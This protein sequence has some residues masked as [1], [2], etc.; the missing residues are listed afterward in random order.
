MKVRPSPYRDFRGVAQPVAAVVIGLGVAIAACGIAGLVL[1]ALGAPNGG[2]EVALGLSAAVTLAVGVGLFRY[3]RHH[4]RKRISRRE[5]LLA[6]CLIWGAAGVFGGLPFVLGAGLS[7]ADA[8]FE[9][10]SG[11]TTTGATVVE[12][13]P[14]QLTRPLMLWRSLIQWLGGMGIVVLFVAV[15]PSLGA[16]GKHMFKGEVPGATAEGLEPRIAETAS[17]LWR[18]YV[19]FTLLEV[20]VLWGLG[21]DPFTAACHAMTT[22]STG[23]FSTFNESAAGFDSPAVEYALSTFM[24]I[25]TVNYGL[26]YAAIK[27]RSARAF[28]RSPEFLVFVVGTLVIT[29]V[30]TV[31]TLDAHGGLLDSLRGSYFMVG[32]TLS[33]TGYGAAGYDAYPPLAISILVGMMFVG[34]CSGSTAGGIK[35]ERVIVLVKQARAQV[36]KSYRPAVVQLIRMGRRVVDPQVVQDV[37]AFFLIY[38][39]CL[40]VGVVFVTATDGVPVETAFG[41]MLT[42]LSNMGPAPFHASANGHFAGY[43]VMPDNF[44]PYSAAAKVFFSLAM[45]L[46]RLEFFTLFALLAPGFWKR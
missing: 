17:T 21:V 40:A 20:A 14:G 16:A 3:G 29:A 44:A 2:G 31:V 33:S 45:L 15:F 25:A 4:V 6:V 18:L 9:A 24:L 30:L 11:L 46:G 27:G 1:E 32:T 37:L 7:P 23:G 41:A 38:I 5:A 43:E 36:H 26:Y 19:V 34:G 13:I 42:C 10:V 12:D 22:M 28:L 39:A 35:I 8:F